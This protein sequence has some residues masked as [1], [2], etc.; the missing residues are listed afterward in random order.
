MISQINLPLSRRRLPGAILKSA[1]MATVAVTATL[2]A[3]SQFNQETG[4]QPEV[5]FRLNAMDDFD[6]QAGPLR[7]QLDLMLNTRRITYIYDFHNLDGVRGA[8]VRGQFSLDMALQRMF[9]GT[10]CAHHLFAKSIEVF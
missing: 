10:G 4:A 6:I 3:K 1:T 9:E 5:E 7:S 8:A 2:L